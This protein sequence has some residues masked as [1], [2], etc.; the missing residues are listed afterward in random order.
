MQSH[1]LAHVAKSFASCS[2]SRDR[3][4]DVKAYH[5]SA[6]R[7]GYGLT[8][9]HEQKLRMKFELTFIRTRVLVLLAHGPGNKVALRQLAAR[10]AAAGRLAAN[11]ALQGHLT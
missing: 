9:F 6:K 11:G 3:R 10:Q 5:L 7:A 2:A 8:R 1:T 4:H